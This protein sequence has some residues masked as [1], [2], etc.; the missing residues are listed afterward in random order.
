MKRVFVLMTV[1][2]FMGAVTG[3]SKKENIQPAATEKKEQIIVVSDQMKDSDRALAFLACIQKNDKKL[4]YEV[5]NLTPKLVEESRKKLTNVAKYKQTPKERAETEHALRMSG[6]IDF[7]LKKLT[8]IFPPSALLQVTKTTQEARA[9]SS[10]NVHLIKISFTNKEDALGDKAGKQI[11]EMVVRLHQIK[12]L[13]NGNTLQE[14]VFDNK[15]FEKMSDK[16][17]EVLS[18]Y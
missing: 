18:Y 13:V 6:N 14:F 12:H 10:I 7:F 3:C 11:K 17:F 5:S 2:V 16:D 1:L 9:D 4:M 15:D 8:K